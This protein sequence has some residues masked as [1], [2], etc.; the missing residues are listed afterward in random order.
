MLNP[1]F[2]LTI[3]THNNGSSRTRQIAI[4]IVVGKGRKKW[5]QEIKG[6]NK[7]LMSQDVPYNK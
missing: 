3:L 7:K 2:L 5:D 6:S 1:R 4:K